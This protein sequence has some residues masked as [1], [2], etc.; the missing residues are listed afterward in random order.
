MRITN[1]AGLPDAFVN[2][3]DDERVPV[4]NVYH[5]TELVE[6]AKMAV[7][8]RRHY[9]EM[10]IDASDCVWL[11]FGQAVHK[12]MEEGNRKDY[13]ELPLSR[14]V[15]DTATLTGR[16]DLW[17]EENGII[18]DYKTATVAKVQRQDFDDWKKQGLEYAWL[19]DG[20][21]K[22]AK[23]L[24]FHALLKDWSPSQLRMA[25]MKGDDTYP[26]HAVWTWEYEITPLDLSDIYH[27]IVVRVGEIEQG[28]KVPDDA[29]E[30]CS[31]DEC[32][33]RNGGFA[34]TKKGG[35]RA[36]KIYSNEDE[37]K[38]VQSTMPGSEVSVRVGE[39]VRCEYYCP[40][41][42]WCQKRKE[43]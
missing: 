18:N 35:K 2:L 16:L 21:G 1:H 17:D 24:R 29:M 5:V 34:L 8:K 40:V 25:R 39:D 22:K 27:W 36:F 11:I 37:A 33:R 20:A 23:R 6:P 28:L 13:A 38:K 12:V 7:L 14:K 10:T 32:W 26:E 43:H 3:A 41:R 4:D 30:C 42:Q 9:S 15:S 31:P 19:L